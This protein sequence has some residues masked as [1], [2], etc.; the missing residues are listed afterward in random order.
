MLWSGTHDDGWNGLG[1]SILHWWSIDGYGEPLNDTS[2]FDPKVAWSAQAP[3]M[4]NF[5]IISLG[6]AVRM[7]FVSAQPLFSWVSRLII[8][9]ANAPNYNQYLMGEYVFP[10]IKLTAGVP[11]HFTS[12]GDALRGWSDAKKTQN[13]LAPD[14]YFPQTGHEFYW[15]LMRGALGM[16]SGEPGGMDAW[17]RYNF[18]I[19]D[20]GTRQGKPNWTIDPTWAIVPITP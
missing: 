13:L 4:N 8:D 5:V 2:I 20:A 18:V 17:N 12:W 16:V 9:Q 3:W 7:G 6:Q 15:D 19:Q 10:D 1:P 11:A 14:T